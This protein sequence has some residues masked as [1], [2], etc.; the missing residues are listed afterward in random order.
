MIAFLDVNVIRDVFFLAVRFVVALGGF[1]VGYVLSGPLASLLARVA[2]HKTLPDWAQAWC[3]VIGGLLVAL[4]AFWL[5]PVGGWGG[6]PGGGGKGSGGGTGNEV[7][8]GS[9]KGTAST[10]AVG[11]LQIDGTGKP[12][13]DS[14]VLVIEMLGPET[15]IEDKCYLINRH[16]PPVNFQTV[17]AYVARHRTSIKAMQILIFREQSVSKGDPVVTKLF[18][19]AQDQKL[20]PP[21]IRIMDTK[22]Q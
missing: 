5:V 1:A 4:L 9:G 19:L 6:G 14:G 17:E 8:S 10:S 21:T 12:V 7:G 2:F 16:Q 3:K 18:N 11:K 15:A 20:D 13:D 22:K